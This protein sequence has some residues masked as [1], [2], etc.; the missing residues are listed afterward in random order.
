MEQ[1]IEQAKTGDRQSLNM[2]YSRYRQRSFAICCHITRDKELSEEL[3]DDAFLIAFSR[4]DQLNDPE[5]FGG[6]L[7]AISAR[8]AMRQMKHPSK[9]KAIPISHIEGFDVPCETDEPPFTQEELQAAIN[10]LPTGYRKVFTM[11]VVEGKPH[12]EIA[13]A[14]NI[15]PHS[16]S[17]QLYHAR[18]MLQRIL[19]PLMCVLFLAMPLVLDQDSNSDLAT[20]TAQRQDNDPIVDTKV[21]PQCS[22]K[23]LVPINSSEFI[24]QEEYPTIVLQN[25]SLISPSP[26]KEEI[27]INKK[28]ERNIDV[29]TESISTDTKL[30]AVHPASKWSVTVVMTHSL[31]Q[32]CVAQHPH[33]L[34]LPS[35][36]T[37]STTGE[38]TTGV[39]IANWRD[40]KQYVLENSVLFS[41]E[42]ASAL[43]RIAQSNEID[44]NGEI[45]RTEYHEPPTIEALMLH[46]AIDSTISVYA[47]VGH[48][49]YRS[50]FQTGVGIDRID[51]CQRVD[52]FDIPVGVSYNLY[53]SSRFGCHLSTDLSLQLPLSIHGST[54]FIL[55]GQTNNAPA[56]ESVI[57]LINHYSHKGKPSLFATLKA[58]VHYR[59]T[60]HVSLFIEGGIGYTIF[61]LSSTEPSWQSLSTYATVHPFTLISHIG[62][63]F[64]F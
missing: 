26:S 55:G 52:F 2:L 31:S 28:V 1:L 54:S 50:Y 37:T 33:P 29:M 14:L 21:L 5:K 47:G 63:R 11:A 62:M 20:L 9:N 39:P 34:L 51:E 30:L 40:C 6:W 61:P 19:G 23:P 49:E 27:E 58:G 59:Q 8:L 25:D 22:F 18:A 64:T 15:E 35:A 4:L 42:V 7:S 46:Y 57:P 12:K 13:Q 24:G 44:N 56:G 45:V 38:P 60:E 3:V 10:Q 43:I 17:S 16:S 36:S 41:D 48:G 32:M 53:Q